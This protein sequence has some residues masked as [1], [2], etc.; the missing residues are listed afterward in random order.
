MP[1]GLK[2]RGVYLCMKVTISPKQRLTNSLIISHLRRALKL[3]RKEEKQEE[4]E[5]LSSDLIKTEQN[6]EAPIIEVPITE[7][8]VGEINGINTTENPPNAEAPPP[9]INEGNN[10]S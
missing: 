7:A 1:T 4:L 5:T 10:N 2:R 9:E 8:P 6:T 3:A